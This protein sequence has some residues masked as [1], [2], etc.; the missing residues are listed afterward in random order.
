MKKQ[1]QILFGSASSKAVAGRRYRLGMAVDSKEPE[2]GVVVKMSMH[3]FILLHSINTNERLLF[4]SPDRKFVTSPTFSSRHIVHSSCLLDDLQHLDL[5]ARSTM[6]L[7]AALCAH[8]ED[9]RG[10]MAQALYKLLQADTV[11]LYVRQ[12]TLLQLYEKM[13]RE[14]LLKKLVSTMI[15]GDTLVKSATTNKGETK[16]LEQLVADF[17]EPRFCLVAK[18]WPTR[19]FKPVS[20]GASLNDKMFIE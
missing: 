8:Q 17:G 13:W 12:D 16:L 14:R 2:M 19:I 3:L 6:F 15:D 5:F 9:K 20:S 7:F 4:L 1:E 18:D 10:W 11:R